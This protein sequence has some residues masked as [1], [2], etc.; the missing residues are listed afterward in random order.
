[1]Y[2]EIKQ[3]KL[4]MKN[5]K[6]LKDYAPG[7]F[8][9]ANLG[10]E[11]YLD[12]HIGVVVKILSPREIKDLI[13]SDRYDEKSGPIVVDFPASKDDLFTESWQ[14]NT[15]PDDEKKWLFLK[16]EEA[17]LRKTDSPEG[18][19][20][21]AEV[22]D[23]EIGALEQKGFRVPYIGFRHVPSRPDGRCCILDCPN[24]E[25]SATWMNHYGSGTRFP[26]CEDH[27]KE[28]GPLFESGSTPFKVKPL[29]K[30]HQP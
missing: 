22:V 1:M 11:Y 7:D 17:L 3:T 21:I 30:E 28:Y 19:L 25:H 20:T 13:A 10:E 9:M 29:E 16:P 5:N 15:A 6:K 27:S 14:T 23:F 24:K 2:F 4:K 8:V 26:V 12:G 18:P